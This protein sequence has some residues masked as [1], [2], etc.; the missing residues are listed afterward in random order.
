MAVVLLALGASAAWGLADFLGGLKSRGTSVLTVLAVSQPVG[1]VFVAAVVAARGEA[2]PGGSALLWA[3]LAGIGSA[4]GI[5]TLYRGLAIGA[6]GVVAPITA[7]APL[8]PLAAALAEGE[9]P[10]TLAGAGIALALAGV[11]LTAWEPDRGRRGRG[12]AALGAGL[13]VIAAIAFGS[14]QVGL[15]AASD[16]DPYWGTLV[17]RLTSCAAVAALLLALR[18]R[19]RAGRSVLPSLALIGVLDIGATVLFAVATTRGLF[20]VAAVLSSLYPLVVALLARLV[21]RERLAPAQRLGAGGAVAG[22]ALI[23]VG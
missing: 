5:G 6:M 9:R 16:A 13:A 22:A 3:A 19:P 11:V 10:T 8:I 2:P 15:E 4:I 7:I 18:H 14:S 1:L 23:S 17:V 21:L 12:R 20:S